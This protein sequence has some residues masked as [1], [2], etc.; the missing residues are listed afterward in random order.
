MLRVRHVIRE[1]ASLVIDE[2]LPCS[3]DHIGFGYW[4]NITSLMEEVCAEQCPVCLLEKHSSFPTVRYMRSTSKAVTILTCTQNFTVVHAFCGSKREIINADQCANQA[5]Y[6]L[7]I[8]SDLQP[9]V[10]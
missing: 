1:R 2:S 7:S 8:G 10:K 4:L 3:V 9:L 5:A 6:G